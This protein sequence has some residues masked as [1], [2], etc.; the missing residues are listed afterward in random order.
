[1]GPPSSAGHDLS[2][3]RLLG[4][5]GEPINPEAWRW[6]RALSGSDKAPV[7]DTW[8]QTET[9]AAMISPLPGVTICKPGSAMRP[10]PGISAKIVDYNGNE[11]IPG[12][13][14]GEQANGYQV[15][16]KPWP[17]ML[18]GIWDDPERFKETYWSAPPRRAGTSPATA[19]AT[20]ATARSGCSAASTTS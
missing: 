4:S 1:M 17:S 18:R 5:V 12:G 15:L 13:D 2:S 6:Y 10:L 9:G 7:V 20:A 3:L 16:D 8:W 11:L 14:H 19:P